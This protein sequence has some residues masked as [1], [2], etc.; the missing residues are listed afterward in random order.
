MR[1]EIDP[2]VARFEA[3]EI[4]PGAFG[5]REHLVCAFGMLRTYPFLEAA[6]R[7]AAAIETMAMRADAPDK[8]HLTVTLAFLSLIA[9]RMAS[10]ETDDV[11][12]FLANNPDLQSPGLLYRWYPKAQLKSDLARTVFVLPRAG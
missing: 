6:N 1:G 7:Y 11:E 3:Q 10:T 9:E 2:M 5:H 4:D 12:A 8:F